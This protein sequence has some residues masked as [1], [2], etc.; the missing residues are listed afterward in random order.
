MLEASPHNFVLV[1]ALTLVGGLTE[2]IGFLLLVP[3]LSLTGIEVDGGA[4]GRIAETISGALLSVGLSPS[5]P[6]ILLC[7]VLIMGGRAF[8][9]YQEAR[10]GVALNEGFARYLRERLYAAVVRSEWKAFTRR[11]PADVTHVMVHEIM[12]SGAGGNYLVKLVT[13][14]GIAPVF[15]ALSFAIAP[16][17]TVIAAVSGGTLVFMLRRWNLRARAAGKAMSSSNNVMFATLHEHLASMKLAKSY[18]AEDINARRFTRVLGNAAGAMIASAHNHNMFKA[19]FTGGSALMLATV[20]Y[21]SLELLHVSGP[22]VLVVL[23]LFARVVPRFATVQTSYQNF[24]NI[25][26]AFSATME[27]I[28]SCERDAEVRSAAARPASLSRGVR[29]ERVG[30]HYDERQERTTVEDLDLWVPAGQ[31]TAIV[32]L[33]GAGKSTIADLLIGLLVPSSGRILVDDEVLG[34][35]LLPSWRSQIGY[36]PQDAFLFHD[37]IRAN[38]LWARPDASEGELWE[39]LRL[40]SAAEF[41][42]RLPL[43]LDAVAGDRGILVSGGERQRLAVARALLRRPRLLILDEATSSLDSLNESAI[44]ATLASLH[45]SLTIVII[46]HRL[47]SVREANLIHVIENGRLAESGDWTAL[48]ARQDGRFRDL[49]RNQGLLDIVVA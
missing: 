40:A 37:T 49:C 20:V 44:K 43:G 24:L 1:L 10:A 6:V 14:L 9:Q 31:T 30:F 28:S 17:V 35:E 39:A 29:F 8:L 19:L 27:Y 47:A 23:F 5:L 7:F 34:P 26:P 32:G 46:T 11:R 33:S 3:L 12:R 13:Q 48:L 4:L 16:A 22:T 42:E 25:L 41:V 2:G 45:G 38:L 15:L 21:V 36:V 18:G